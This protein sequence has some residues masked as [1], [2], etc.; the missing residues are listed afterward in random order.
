MQETRFFNIWF[1]VIRV[2]NIGIS[3]DEEN[4]TPPVGIVLIILI[5]YRVKLAKV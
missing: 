2:L 3:N 1:I 5:I 4:L